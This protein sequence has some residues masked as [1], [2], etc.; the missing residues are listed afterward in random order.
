[1]MKSAK[2]AIVNSKNLRGD[3]RNSGMIKLAKKNNKSK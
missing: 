1:M 3:K 2:S